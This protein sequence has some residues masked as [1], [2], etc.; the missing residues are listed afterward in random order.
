[1]GAG[2]SGGKQSRLDLVPILDA[3]V[4]VIFFLVLSMSFTEF[5]QI[6]MPPTEVSESPEESTPSDKKTS[7]NPKLFAKANNGSIHLA[8]TWAGGLQNIYQSKINIAGDQHE[9]IQAEAA[10]LVEQFK[11][12]FPNENLLIVSANRDL[13]FQDFV[14]LIDGSKTKITD[15]IMG[16]YSNSENFFKERD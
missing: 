16:S 4:V 2:T 7:L 1:M 6:T 14:A 8:L 9:K 11:N 10:R 12:R 13:R 5:T 15:V 3:L